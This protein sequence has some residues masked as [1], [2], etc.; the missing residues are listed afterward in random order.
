MGGRSAQSGLGGAGGT[1]S[2]GGGAPAPPD[3]T[4]Q[5]PQGVEDFHTK[6]EIA[7]YMQKTYGI[8]VDIASMGRIS[9][10]ALREACRGVEAVLKAFPK[11]ASAFKLISG[12]MHHRNAIAEASLDGEIHINPKYYQSRTTLEKTAQDGVA[13]KW[14]P[15][16]SGRFFT[17]HEA[18]H[19]LNA[20]LIRQV[21][22]AQAAAETAA[23]RPPT[24]WDISMRESWDWSKNV[25]ARNIMSKAA[26]IVQKQ[27]G[28]RT[29]NGKK[30]QIA[31]VSGYAKK[32]DAE[33]LAECV[34]D[35][36]ANGANA[37]P[38]SQAVWSLLQKELA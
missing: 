2:A 5:Q 36:A 34:A 11:T 13:T 29:G 31:K 37:Q 26:A 7:D 1:G 33:A 27:S 38:I 19:I 23:G 14:H 25:T 28:Q 12:K 20:V 18:G 21:V 4:P 24:R 15:P 10:K 30:V 3:N 35:F 32:N 8:R 22:A 17:T 9:D 16:G 6:Q